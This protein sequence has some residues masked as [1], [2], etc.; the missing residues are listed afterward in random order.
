MEDHSKLLN[1]KIF[2]MHFRNTA[3]ADHKLFSLLDFCNLEGLENR[4]FYVADA[5][6]GSDDYTYYEIKKQI[7]K[8]GSKQ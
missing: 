8:T 2:K 1:A 6:L 7:L 3:E 4:Q 5:V